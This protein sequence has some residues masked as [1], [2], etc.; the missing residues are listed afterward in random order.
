M[1]KFVVVDVLTDLA[2]AI[3]SALCDDGVNVERSLD[4]QDRADR[5]AVHRE[6]GYGVDER[7][8]ELVRSRRRAVIIAR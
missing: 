3:F 5:H 8:Q 1:A 2:A 7:H 6:Q 4:K